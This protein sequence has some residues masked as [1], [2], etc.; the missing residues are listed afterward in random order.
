MSLQHPGMSLVLQV[1]DIGVG[2]RLPLSIV[3]NPAW[4]QTAYITMMTQVLHKG[5]D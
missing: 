1:T 4:L 3:P 5:T 2:M